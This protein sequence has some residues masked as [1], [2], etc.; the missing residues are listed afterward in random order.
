MFAGTLSSFKM[1]MYIVTVMVTCARISEFYILST[2][3][4]KGLPP[5][6][7]VVPVNIMD[8]SSPS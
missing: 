1:Y 4:Q 7:L 8:I 6:V 2:Q 5:H 3:Q